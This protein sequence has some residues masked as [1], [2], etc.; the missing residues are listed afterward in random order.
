VKPG[1]RRGEVVFAGKVPHLKPGYWVGVRFDEPVGKGD[2]TAGGKRYFDADPRYGAFARPHNVEVGDFPVQDDLFDSDLD[3][4]DDGVDADGAG[5]GADEA[6]ASQDE[7]KTSP[8]EAAVDAAADALAEVSV[9]EAAAPAATPA[10]AAPT[11]AAAPVA[12][13]DSDDEL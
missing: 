6:K 12:D 13:A 9:A 3:D 1:A 8:D 10:A 7:A 4:S 11:A 5:A 2:G